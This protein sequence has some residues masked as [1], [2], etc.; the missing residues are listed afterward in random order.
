MR[1]IAFTVFT[2]AAAVT[3]SACAS[4]TE[5]R[6]G[7]EGTGQ[8]K[9][10]VINGEVDK[11]AKYDS[12]LLIETLLNPST[13]EAA[14]CTGTLISPHV[15]ITARHCVSTLNESTGVFGADWKPENMNVWY[16]PE[17][18]GAPDLYVARIVHPAGSTIDNNDFAM[19]VLKSPASKP[20]SP[21]RL[22]APPKTGE[23]TAVAGYGLT[24]MDTGTPTELHKRYRRENL[25]ILAVGPQPMY[26]LG[27]KEIILGESICSGDSGGPVFDETTS[28]LLAVTSRG[29]NGTMPTA[30]AP[31]AGCTGSRAYNIF[32]RV[33]GFTDLIKKTVGE[34][35]EEVWEEGTPKPTPPTMPM[36]D[37]GALGA[38]CASPTEC[39]SKLCVDFGGSKTCSQACS[40]S[41]PCPTGFDC[42]SGYCAPHVD[43]PP[44]TDPGTDPAADPNAATD[45]GGTVKK[46]GCSTSG[47]SSDPFAAML[48][49]G[50]G[51]MLARRASVRRS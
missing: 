35:G 2:L 21:I 32:T 14:G 49:V 45:D 38:V 44:G 17:P 12:V 37:P 16:G 41:A 3:A 25:S 34:V 22:A 18:R 36:P 42:N 39:A 51:I 6:T 4:G 29:G 31:Y 47:G 48:L 8:S 27:S 15:L 46:G 9:S 10:A 43:A 23:K 20:F 26:G 40:D 13:G 19:L 24:T 1:T 50:A 5:Q 11:P 28:A 7:S 33:D 30:S